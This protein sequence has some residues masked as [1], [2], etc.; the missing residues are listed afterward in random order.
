MI[1]NE[2]LAKYTLCHVARYA[3]ATRD[4]IF[5]GLTGNWLSGYWNLSAG[6]AYHEGWI[7]SSAGTNDT[8]W[9]VMCDTGGGPSGLRSNG[10]EKASVINSAV[11]LPA[12][13]TINLQGGRATTAGVSD[14]E[15]AGDPEAPLVLYVMVAVHFA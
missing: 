12:N 9:R 4:R 7:T 10:V 3:G 8:N 15:V 11:G 6:V 13:I 2:A 14:W 5:A 1:G